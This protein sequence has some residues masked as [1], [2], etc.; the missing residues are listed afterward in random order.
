MGK[1]K[2]KTVNNFYH[3]EDRIS[4]QLLRAVERFRFVKEPKKIILSIAAF[5]YL[6]IDAKVLYGKDLV[7]YDHH[8]I[9]N[10]RIEIDKTAEEIFWSVQ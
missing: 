5:Y 9:W 3:L 1:V 8:R 2:E 4:T 6:Q 7:Y 10:I